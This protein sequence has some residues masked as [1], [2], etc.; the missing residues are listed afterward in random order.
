MKTLVQE[1]R[2]TLALAGPII[3]GQVSQ[4]VMGVTDSIMI[5]HVG[6]VPLAASAFANSVWGFAFML[7]IGLL[8]PVAV[9]VPRAHGAGRDD[10]CAE[11]LRHGVAT[12]IAA[13]AL[14][15]GALWLL[16]RELHRFGQPEEVLLEVHPYFE[17]IAISL[18]PTL[19]FQAFRQ[20]S[21]SLGK[22]G[23]PMVFLLIGVTLNIFLNWVLIYGN[24]GAPRLGLSG[25]AWATLI[26]RSFSLIIIIA[27]LG[28]LKVM[29]PVWPTRWLKRLSGERF[30][31]MFAIGVPAAVSLMFEGGAFSAAAFLMGLLGATEL[32]A[33]QIALSCA[34][35]T[36]MIPLGISTAASMRIGRAVGQQRASDVRS[37]GVSATMTAALIMSVFAVIFATSGTE[38]ASVFVKETDVIA[39]AAKLLVIAAVFQLFDGSQVVAAGALRGLADVKVATVITGFAYWGIALPGAWYFGLRTSL[40]ARGVW[41]ALAVGLAIAAILLF[42]RFMGRSRLEV[43]LA[44]PAPSQV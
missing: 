44:S 35:F 3:V 28:R 34:A 5:G 33:H 25:A 37:I 38:I 17:I 23:G 1:A 14:A 15:I 43:I 16:G 7:G 2:R 27:W 4:M 6:K 26:A 24:L 12:A 30:R 31:S 8:V 13:S 18:F 32:A 21:E 19:L 10:A 40:G 39:L 41:A 42:V 11:W 29:R 20:F 36:F 9:L 22:P